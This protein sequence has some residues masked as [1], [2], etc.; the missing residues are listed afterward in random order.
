LNALL[1]VFIVTYNY[2]QFLKWLKNQVCLDT[3][4]RV[5]AV[6]LSIIMAVGVISYFKGILTLKKSDIP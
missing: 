4:E 3:H 6:I 5:D 1:L 2:E